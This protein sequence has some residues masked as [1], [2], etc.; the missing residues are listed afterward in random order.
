[1]FGD[2]IWRNQFHDFWWTFL[3]WLRVDSVTIDEQSAFKKIVEV[4]TWDNGDFFKICLGYQINVCFSKLNLFTRAPLDIE[5]LKCTGPVFIFII[6]DFY[7]LSFVNA[8]K[9]PRKSS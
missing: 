3:D 5:E 4:F 7:F 9:Q 2:L 1:M 6:F 8:E